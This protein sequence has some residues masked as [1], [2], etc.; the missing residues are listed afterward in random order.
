ML[1]GLVSDTSLDVRVVFSLREDYLAELEDFEAALPHLFD[2]AYRLAALT[3]FGAREAI[4]RPL[5]QFGV[6][7]SP[8]IVTRMVEQLDSVDLDPPL[9]QIFCTEVYRQAIDRDPDHPEM[10]EEDVRQVG[11]LD[12]IFRRYL[13]AVT[14]DP[15]LLADPLL[16]RSV[17]DALLTQEHTKRAATVDDIIS[18]RFR[19]TKEEVAPILRLLVGR[20]LLRRS[21][22]DRVEWF[23]L[24]HERL[25]PFVQEWLDRDA[26][27][28]NFRLARDLIAQ[29]NRGEYWRERPN[30]LLNAG[31]V[32]EVV[33][34]YR[35]RLWL[36]AS[37]IEFVYFSALVSRSNE[38]GYWA[39]QVG[40]DKA[41]SLLL[42]ALTS[43]DLRCG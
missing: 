34:P 37:E 9:L 40:R 27:F 33:G 28:L 39:D 4:T 32:E 6:R 26:T 3:A 8:T 5:D 2:R 38:A 11:G 30:L 29:N 23:E 1:N 20:Y 17:L 36:S 15:V 12:G 25:V 42:G 10:T 7:Y 35:G 21:I 14:E 13:N 43:P 19:A 41:V 18:S 22:R 16:A 24:I 31:Q